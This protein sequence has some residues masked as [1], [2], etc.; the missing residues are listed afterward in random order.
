M[1]E[2]QDIIE[3]SKRPDANIPALLQTCFTRGFI[4][5]KNYEKK[6]ILEVINEI[7]L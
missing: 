7:K 2:I 4:E 1:M 5:G 3:I 6:R